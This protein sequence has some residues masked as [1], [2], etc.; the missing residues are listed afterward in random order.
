MVLCC[1]DIDSLSRACGRGASIEKAL[2]PNADTSTCPCHWSAKN[3]G[4]ENEG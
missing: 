2:L 4:V 3:A 1:G